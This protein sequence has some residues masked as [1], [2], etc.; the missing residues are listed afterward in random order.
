MVLLDSSTFKVQF[1]QQ[2]KG[3]EK[4]VR[5]VEYVIETEKATDKLLAKVEEISGGIVRCVNQVFKKV[6]QGGSWS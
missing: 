1:C 4:S 6:T 3:E 5:R 2:A